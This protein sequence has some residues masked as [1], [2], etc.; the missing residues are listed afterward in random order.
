MKRLSDLIKEYSCADCAAPYSKATH[1]HVGVNN[2]EV[3][4]SCPR[5][6]SKDILRISR[7]ELHTRTKENEAEVE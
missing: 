2:Y 3:L 6:Y 5:C 7:G 1:I 4:V